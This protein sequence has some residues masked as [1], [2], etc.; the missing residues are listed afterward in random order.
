M[1]LKLKGQAVVITGAG[2][3]IG[4]EAARVFGAEGAKVV[5]WDR[6]AD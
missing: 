2:R 3:G 4:A 6:D 1:D 5:V